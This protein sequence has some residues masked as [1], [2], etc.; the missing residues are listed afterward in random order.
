M[1]KSLEQL[2]YFEKLDIEVY[3]SCCWLLLMIIIL[4]ENLRASAYGIP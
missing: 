3:L 1:N 4:I 2:K